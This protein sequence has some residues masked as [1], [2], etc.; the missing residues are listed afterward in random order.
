MRAALLTAGFLLMT[1]LA[2]RPQTA[3]APA[4]DR[5]GLGFFTVGLRWAHLDPLH[6]ALTGAG[7]APLADRFVSLG[8]GGW[9]V[10]GRLLLG[11]EGYG[12]LG[13]RTTLGDR[14]ARLAGG[15]GF[16]DLGYV[17]ARSSA[18][19]AYGLVGLGGGRWSLRIQEAGRVPD[20]AGLLRRPEGSTRLTTGGFLLQ[21]AVGLDLGAPVVRRSGYRGDFLVGLRVGY[22]WQPGGEGWRLEGG[23]PVVGGPDVRLT[24]PTVYLVL[25]WQGFRARR[26]EAARP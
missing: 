19:R 8:G 11:G 16:F 21:T 13:Q 20:F 15:Y 14:E 6:R 7:F 5:G 12:L 2:A 9:A 4:F 18:V 25:G 24:G 22:V 17:I 1:P 23:P 26:P 3:P 10:L